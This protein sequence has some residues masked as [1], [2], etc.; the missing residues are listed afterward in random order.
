M[1]WHTWNQSNYRLNSRLLFRLAKKNINALQLFCIKQVFNCSKPVCIMQV[2]NCLDLFKYLNW[3]IALYRLI[4]Y[5]Q[6]F[7]IDLLPT[8][9]LLYAIVYYLRSY[10]NLQ[11]LLFLKSNCQPP[12]HL[13]FRLICILLTTHYNWAIRTCQLKLVF[14]YA[15][16][17]HII[18]QLIYQ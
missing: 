5:K 13:F 15:L 9:T 16:I 3:F 7:A 14:A 1:A 4:I 12:C 17:I 10:F 2:F 8:T 6:F 11:A 18:W